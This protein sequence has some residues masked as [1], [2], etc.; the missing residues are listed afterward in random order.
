MTY[1]FNPEKLHEI[2]KAAVGQQ[3]SQMFQ[4]VLDDLTK[5]YGSHI[6]PRKHWHFNNAGGAMG[7][8]RLLHASLSEYL[9]FFGTPIGTEGH[10]GRYPAAVYDFML[11]GDMWCYQE[12]ETER[13]LYKP[14]D[15]AVLPKGATKGYRL[16]KGAWM[17]EYARGPIVTMLPF[18]FLDVFTSTLDVR[19]MASTF[20]DYTSLVLQCSWTKW[21]SS[22]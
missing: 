7:Q 21:R 11:D 10:S 8:L 4:Q 13:I 12:G 5:E 3:H 1:I 19:A 18:G 22:R 16:P 6:R 20:V 15:A 14:G 2:A 17:L 9:I